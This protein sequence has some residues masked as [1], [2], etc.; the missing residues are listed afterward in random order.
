MQ[1]ASSKAEPKFDKPEKAMMSQQSMERDGT[2]KDRVS[3]QSHTGGG[4]YARPP[5][6]SSCSM[7]NDY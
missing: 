3:E 7:L 1:E 2:E 6:R 4:D 5:L